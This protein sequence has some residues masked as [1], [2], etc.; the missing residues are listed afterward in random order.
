MPYEL[1]LDHSRVAMHLMEPDTAY[2]IGD[3]D[4]RAVYLAARQAWHAELVRVLE[5]EDW[6]RLFPRLGHAGRGAA[7]VLLEHRFAPAELNRLLARWWN[8]TEGVR[9]NETVGLFGRAGFVSGGGALP[10]GELTVYRGCRIPRHRLGTSWTL[11]EERARFFAERRAGPNAGIVYQ[12]RV[13]SSDVL[14]YFKS[15]EEEEVVVDPATLRAVSR[16]RA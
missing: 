13:S 6:D 7:F 12:A 15:R 2:L 5:R 8:M 10:Q 11:E 14:G 4:E 9:P 1:T 3:A 16:V